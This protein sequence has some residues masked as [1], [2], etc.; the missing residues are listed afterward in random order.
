M[1]IQVTYNE[2]GG[3]EA[4]AT[5]G[6]YFCTC[7]GLSGCGEAH[8]E[9]N[10]D[11]KISEDDREELRDAAYQKVK[12]EWDY[13]GSNWSE[14]VDEPDDELVDEPD[15]EHPFAVVKTSF[16]GGGIKGYAV[17]EESA[18]SWIAR[19]N[20][21]SDCK[22]GCYGVCPVSELNDLPSNDGN[23]HDPYSLMG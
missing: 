9:D 5:S 16:H 6:D 3:H 21:G 8:F 13:D 7:C 22:C 20:A 23:Q 12:A 1:N 4:M 17:S 18:E 14:P 19:L 2:Q 10:F 15:E 11:S